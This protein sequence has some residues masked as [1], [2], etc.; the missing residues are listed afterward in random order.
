MSHVPAKETIDALYVF[1]QSLWV[2]NHVGLK[3]GKEA[4]T[5]TCFLDPV[6]ERLGWQFIPELTQKN[7]KRPDYWLFS[8][9]SQ[10]IAAAEAD[11]PE[12]RFRLSITVLEAKQFTH[13]LDAVSQKETPG[14][15]PSQQVQG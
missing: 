4:Y 9:E 12:H 2:K 15:F 6:L 10:R 5:R 7:Q 13:P 3:K 8:E 14:L 1:A 11:E